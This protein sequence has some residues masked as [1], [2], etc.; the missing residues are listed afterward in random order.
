M[1]VSLWR[2]CGFLGAVAMHDGPEPH[3]TGSPPVTASVA[4]W[5]RCPSR[6][7]QTRFH[8]GSFSRSS[9]TGDFKIGTPAATLPGAW[10]YWV[11]VGTDLPGVD[12]LWLGEIEKLVGK[13]SLRQQVQFSEP[14]RP[15]D[16]LAYCLDVKQ[17]ADNNPSCLGV[18]NAWPQVVLSYQ[19][20]PL[21]FCLPMFFVVLSLSSSS[22]SFFFFLLFFLF[23]F[24]VVFFSSR[25]ELR[26]KRQQ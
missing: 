21:L 12:M 7:R 2:P 3:E 13:F 10:L 25:G 26:V 6:D 19:F 4:K 23:W 8:N 14:S 20:P 17:P 18:S 11:S 16:T 22:S 5:L 24:Y 15:W 9:H 1:F